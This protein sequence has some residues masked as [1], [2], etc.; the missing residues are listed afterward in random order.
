MGL[1]FNRDKKANGSG[2]ERSFANTYDKEKVKPAIRC[3]I[4]TG[5][6]VAG[7]LD[8]RSGNF[9]EIALIRQPGDLEDFKKRF[10][11]A[12]EVEKFY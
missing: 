1:F 10:G 11:I 8:K 6:Q 4:C 5:E 12:G 2:A 9:E 3:S 7:F